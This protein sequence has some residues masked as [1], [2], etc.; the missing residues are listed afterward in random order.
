MRFKCANRSS[1]FLR[2]RRDCSKPSVPASEG[3][4]SGVFMDVTRDLARR[5]LWAALR[6]ER[7]YVAVELACTI[8]KRLALVNGA[9]CSELLSARAMVDVAGRIILEVA[10][11]E[12][13]VIPL[14][15]IEHRDVWCDA[16]LFDQPVQH[17]S[18]P[19]GGI[20]NK[21]IRLEAEALLC[22]LDHSL[23]RADLGLANGAGRLDIN[24][25]AET[26]E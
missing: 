25:D 3:N 4:V 13:A 11:R 1:I 7:A 15:L 17:R 8:Q 20:A 18:C 22:S 24:D 14:R 6:F 12:S 16:F 23:R 2:S 9:A 5:L 10:A 26:S 21:P 19:I